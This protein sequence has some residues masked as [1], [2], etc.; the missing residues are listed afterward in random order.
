MYLEEIARTRGSNQI[1]C[2]AVGTCAQASATGH[3]GGDGF[4][5]GVHES[6]AGLS[7]RPP[8]MTD[9]SAPCF[10]EEIFGP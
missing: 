7:G 5:R 3:S 1:G 2:Q 6:P 8:T 10:G 9:F 4:H